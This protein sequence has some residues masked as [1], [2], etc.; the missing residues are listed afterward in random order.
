MAPTPT[1]K[2]NIVSPCPAEAP[3]HWV[4]QSVQAEL[5]HGTFCRIVVPNLPLNLSPRSPQAWP[6]LA[7]SQDPLRSLAGDPGLLSPGSPPPL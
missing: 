1:R 5:Q 6:R 4:L 2:D 7:R 3:G